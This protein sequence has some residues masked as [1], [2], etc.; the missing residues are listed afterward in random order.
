MNRFRSFVTLFLFSAAANAQQLRPA[1]SAT[2]YHE[3]AQLRNL[4]NV[5]YVAAHPD[6]ENTRLLAYLVN[7]RHMRTAYLSLTRGDGGQNLLGSEQG[8]ALGLIRTHE[9][10]EARKL[11]GAEQ[12]FT[13]AVDFGFSKTHEETFRHWRQDVLTGDAVQVIR[14]FRPDV[15]ICR[16]PPDTMA[17]HGQHAASA[18]IAE[19]AYKAAGDKSKYPEQLRY[20]GA[21][22]P[23]RLLFNSFK[24]GTRSTISE[25]QF[26]LQVGQY[27]PALGMGVGELA[28]QSRSIHKSQG[29]GTPSVPG[30]QTEYFKLVA[31]D[32]CTTSLFDGID[33]TWGR[34]GRADI[35]D[36]LARIEQQFSFQRPEASIPAL[37]AVRKKITQVKDEYWRG[38]KLQEIDKAILH[39]AGVM[40]ELTTRQPQA[41]RGETVPFAMRMIARTA[42]SNIVVTG[43]QWGGSD[44]TMSLRLAGDTLYTFDHSITIPANAP[45]TQPYWMERAGTD[46]A[47]YYMPADTVAGLPE[48]PNRLY[49]T[50]KLQVSG[51]E[52]SIQVPLS[53]KKL[54]PVKGDVVEQLRIVP[55]GTVAF[56]NEL[57]IA[58]PDGSATGA[59]RV[60]AYND[61]K[62]AYLSVVSDAVPGALMELQGFSLRKGA[63]TLI[64][65]RIAARKELAGKDH[66]LVP[67][68]ATPNSATLHLVQY[69]HLPAL[70]YFSN[71]VATV[72]QPSWKCTAKKIG[73]VEGAGDNIPTILRQAGLEVEILKESDFASVQG[74][75]KYDAIITGIR[76]ANAEKR[77]AQWQPMLLQYAENGGT[78]VMQ[79]NTLQDLATSKLGPY[80]FSLSSKRVTEED[81]AVT[82]TAADHRLLTYPNKITTEDMNGWV[83][84]RGLYFPAEWDGRYT[85]I[86]SMNDQG[87]QPLAGSTLYAKTG[88]GHY[89]YTSLSFSRQL[90][91]GKKGATKLLMNM[92]SVG[93]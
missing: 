14:R 70:Q 25:D 48:T 33:I 79:Y 6:D 49:A 80:P 38:Q 66:H 91:A 73:Y 41:V 13:R 37:L 29:A 16:F 69:D 81:A 75:M 67:M 93:K 52:F 88:K 4:T 71:P 17:G 68:L 72:L 31:G 35:G 56:S 78:L 42:A 24:F 87:E 76:A 89:V 92:I 11:D 32:A 53:Y 15:V 83:Q 20:Y 63:D 46:D 59:I 74:L 30:V 45:V 34:V 54:D 86:F 82:F 8:A 44:S 43:I 39:C 12:F 26:K 7:D 19:L 1:S 61:I 84:E 27:V 23:K 10:I 28:G 57:L 9:L 51:E 2:I 60:H 40:A 64:P 50:V 3:I 21:W 47:H 85:T 22:Q 65:V 55:D 36:D 58:A 77:M 62:S 90:P 18:I 5:L